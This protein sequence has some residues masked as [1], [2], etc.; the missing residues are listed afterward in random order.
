MSGLVVQVT[1]G[2]AAEAES[3]E[4]LATRT[5]TAKEPAT[6]AVIATAEATFL[7]FRA[8]RGR[9][10]VDLIIPQ[11]RPRWLFG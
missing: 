10:Y 7:N 1:L 3:W 6:T 4:L 8:N 9:R 5:E 2:P 11:Q